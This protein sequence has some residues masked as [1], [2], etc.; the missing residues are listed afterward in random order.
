[1]FIVV[2]VVNI[3]QVNYLPWIGFFSKV[4]SADMYVMFDIVDFVNENWMHRNRIKGPGGPI[5][6]TIPIARKYYRRPFLEVMLP[7]DRRWA[8]KHWKTILACYKKADYFESYSSFF[9]DLY[10]NIHRYRTLNELNSEIIL[11]LLKVLDIDVEVIRASELDIPPGLKKTDLVLAVLEAV[12]GD[13]LITGTGAKKYLDVKKFEE[14]GH[15][16]IFHEFRCPRYKQLWE[17]PGF[18]PNLSVIDLLFN[19]GDKAPE[20]LSKTTARVEEP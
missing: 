17:D 11:H 5:W 7:E 12:G 18:I 3:H 8:M 14:R 16:V 2:L 6:L 10:K 19:E 13:V 4:M 9:E 1:V 20:I 15:R